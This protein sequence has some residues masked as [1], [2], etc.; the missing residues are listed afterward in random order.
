ME[1]GSDRDLYYLLGNKLVDNAARWYT[2]MSKRLQRHERTWTNLK[3]ALLRRYGERRDK[4]AAEMR[5]MQRV[6]APGE[7][8]ADF[9][10]GLRE[11]AGRSHVSERVLLNQFYRCLEMTVR[12]LV[13]MDP[14][15]RT[16]EEA[17]EKAMDI[18]HTNA[19]VAQGMTNIG[20]Y[21]PQAPAPQVIRVAGDAGM[22]AVLPGVGS[23]RMP[24]AAAAA[25]AGHGAM[26]DVDTEGFAA[27]TNPRGVHNELTGIWEA[28]PGRT[29]NGR[30]WVPAGKAK[31]GLAQQQ[32]QQAEKRA[33][34]KPDKKAKA[35]MVRT[36]DSSE[37]DEDE[38]DTPSPP[39][40][41]KLKAPIRQ[42]Q[43]TPTETKTSTAVRPILAPVG[44][45]PRC[46]ACGRNGH[47]A[48]ECTDPAAKA[49]NDAYLAARESK[50]PKAENGEAAQ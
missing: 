26:S 19:N 16:L 35:L 47:F 43:S 37:D 4:G 6:F 34:K 1:D 7:T 23:T 25:P 14:R 45:A 30:Q 41:K 48:R 10:A 49:R 11:A 46:Y 28:P 13:R 42:V 32:Q 40:R 39:P 50:S 31:R 38:S 21:W 15:P 29:W 2:G 22:A 33:G 8:Y 27:F 44:E 36:I 5:V 17:V 20:Q 3:R 18:D 12:V 24:A 9:A